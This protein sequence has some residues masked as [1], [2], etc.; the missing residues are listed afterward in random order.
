MILVR[1][2]AHPR[3]V[4]K[5]NMYKDK[6]FDF[7]DSGQAGSP[8]KASFKG[9]YDA[10]LVPFYRVSKS[11]LPFSIAWHLTKGKIIQVQ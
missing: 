10:D 11:S 2:E 1:P 7:Y 4:L 8:S 3:P 9:Q 6:G 5:A